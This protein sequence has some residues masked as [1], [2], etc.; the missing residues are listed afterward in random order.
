MG[1]ND[2]GTRGEPMRTRT[3]RALVAAFAAG[4]LL[5]LGAACGDDGDTGT[6]GTAEGPPPDATTTTAASG[7]S[8]TASGGTGATATDKV[9]V[10]QF[11]FTPKEIKV[12]KGATVTWT[13]EDSA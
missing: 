1:G 6:V 8:T 10:K 7:A 11:Q 13:N 9:S 2:H 3:R 4:A 5:L 12:A